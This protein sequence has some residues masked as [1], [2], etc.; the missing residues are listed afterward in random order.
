MGKSQ[1]ITHTDTKTGKTEL[2]ELNPNA[3]LEKPLSEV[4]NR[5]A[6]NEHA[7]LERKNYYNVK[8]R[9]VLLNAA[10]AKLSK[11]KLRQLENNTKPAFFEFDKDI[12]ENFARYCKKNKVS[13]KQRL[14]LY[15][16]QV[17]YVEK[18]GKQ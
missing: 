4:T 13:M 2:L 3:S 11:A 14:E 15:M 1:V 9:E 18:K 10:K 17:P 7:L 5:A 8:E 16:S 12:Y 6:A